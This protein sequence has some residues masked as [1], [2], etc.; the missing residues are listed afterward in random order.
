MV[1]SEM[2]ERNKV[3]EED[4]NMAKNSMMTLITFLRVFFFLNNVMGAD[5]RHFDG[6]LSDKTN[7]LVF[8]CI[9]LLELIVNYVQC[10]HI[11]FKLI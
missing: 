8:G 3:W 7:K 4:G 11:T 10:F 5:T 9:C 1:G 6:L 2:K